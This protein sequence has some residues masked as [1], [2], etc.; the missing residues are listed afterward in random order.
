MIKAFLSHSSANKELVRSVAN[1][2]G[3][4]FCLIDEQVF[5][6]GISFKQSIEKHL[7]TTSVF[8]LFLSTS[9]LQ[10]VWVN[11]EIDESAYRVIQNTISRAIVFMIDSDVDHEALP[12]WLKR[13][14]VVRNIVPKSIA[15]E[16]R[17]HI[18]D[19]LR[20]EQHMF[21]EGRTTD[22]LNFQKV[23]TPID[24]APPRLVA[25]HGLPSIG[26]RSFLR[27]A[28]RI[29][30]GFGRII[31]FEVAE[32]DSLADLAI[33]IANELEPYSTSVGF[34]HIVE[35]IRTASDEAV[36]IRIIG[37]LRAAVSNRELPVL[38]DEGGL[39][40]DEGLFTPSVQSLVSAVLKD[41]QLYLCVVS[42]RKPYA[43]I[44]T[45]SLGPLNSDDIRR[46]IVRI[47]GHRN[48]PLTLTSEH[49]SELAEYVNGYP[50]SAYFAVSL[51][52]EYGVSAVL[53]DKSRLVQFR[54]AAM[55]RYLRQKNLNVVERKVLS[56]LGR[57][58]PLPIEVLPP[59]IGHTSA[60]IAASMMRLMDYSL[61]VL[62]QSGLY[63]VAGPIADVVHR[64]ITEPTD[65]EA[66]YNAVIQL[67]DETDLNVPRLDLHRV[68]FRAATLGNVDSKQ[69]FHMASD[70]IRLTE[71]F[72]HDRNYRKAIEFGRIAS[73]ERPESTVARD[74]LIRAL[75]QEEAW[76]DA[77]L[78]IAKFSSIAVSRDISYLKGF[79]ERKRGKLSLAIA[80]YLEAI[81]LGR[82]GQGIQREVA[83][84][85]YLANNIIEAKRHLE[86]LVIKRDNRIALDLWIQ[87]AIRE[88]D[89]RTARSALAQLEALEF[90]W[91][92][93]HRLSTVELGFG[94]VSKALE[95]AMTAVSSM[96]DGRPTFGML[97]Q[98]ATCQIRIGD[99]CSAESTLAKLEVAYRNQR[100]DVR[101]GLL[102]RLEIERKRFKK[103]LEIFANIGNNS[104]PVYK[105]MRRDALLGELET[106]ALSDADRAKYQ[107]EIERLNNELRSFDTATGWLALVR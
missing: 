61:V 26:R 12:P 18:D 76:S 55:V 58:S 14:K 23:L 6:N 102:C 95:A 91:F 74:Y 56:V 36:V 83:Y 64:E 89:E 75:I 92:F 60:D 7:D 42:A 13:A 77:E 71:E 37:D 8:V 104:A 1:N 51:A 73:K 82:S 84:C 48:P 5:E 25:V 15:R 32:G 90:P 80:H 62:E 24:R 52:A 4:Q 40:T 85:Y 99:F 46:L 22:L 41:S 43:D 21:F 28:A 79:L 59:V 87:I 65:H 31:V 53:A 54:T 68:L 10:S 66:L 33:R 78:E 29:S 106:S 44:Q 11:F 94:Y 100:I 98:L 27:N 3:R 86:P 30:L 38:L 67:V 50:P 34:E 96:K 103:A 69:L 88:Q 81:K 93:Y 20:A 57:Y 63:A 45:Q 107:L 17:E 72:Y 39:L 9:A 2:L 16:I 49:V 97:A 105:A 70:I 35:T 47:S 101:I 19:L